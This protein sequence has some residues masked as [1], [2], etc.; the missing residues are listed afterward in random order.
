MLCEGE[1]YV[2]GRIKDLLI[3]NGRNLYPQDIEDAVQDVH[4]ALTGSR[5]CA[6]AVDGGGVERALVI[7]AVK[8]ELLGDATYDRDGSDLLSRGLYLDEGPWQCHA[9]S[10]EEMRD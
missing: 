4:P 1:L 8:P 9:F 6:V 2:T 7:Q 5:G 10:M 3:V